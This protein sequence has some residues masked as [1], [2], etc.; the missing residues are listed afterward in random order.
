M[1]GKQ[2]FSNHPDSVATAPSG[3]LYGTGMIVDGVG[4]F[5]NHNPLPVPPLASSSSVLPGPS[6]IVA[7]IW[8]PKFREYR[9]Y[10]CDLF[11]ILHFKAQA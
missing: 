8:L 3:R 7:V 4:P 10:F 9:N 5:W 2:L 11:F 1:A 6:Q